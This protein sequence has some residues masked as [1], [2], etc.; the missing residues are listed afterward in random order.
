MYNMERH[1]R[2][3][4]F[5]PS[6]Y[7]IHN[8]HYYYYGLRQQISIP[9]CHSYSVSRRWSI[10]SEVSF[11][12][13]FFS[14]GMNCFLQSKEDATA[15]KERWF[16]NS[17][18][19]MHCSGWRWIAKECNA[20]ITRNVCR[21]W[22]VIAMWISCCHD[23]CGWKFDLLHCPTPHSLHKSAWGRERIR[24]KERERDRETERRRTR[25]RTRRTSTK[26]SAPIQQ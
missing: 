22:Y 2:C 9:A 3:D 1:T 17:F 4:V 7:M 13:T 10:N 5:F 24:E 21:G 25:T 20:H 6:S 19:W 18:G 8:F 12:T 16:S 26:K 23:S 14:W 15:Q 11:Q